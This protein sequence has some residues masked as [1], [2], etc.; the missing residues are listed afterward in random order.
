LYGYT[1]Y[2]VCELAKNYPNHDPVP[3]QNL[4]DAIAAWH[5]DHNAEHIPDDDVLM[6]WADRAMMTLQAVEHAIC[7]RAATA[8]DNGD[9]KTTSGKLTEK[10]RNR[11]V[12]DRIRE[13][14]SADT[15]I[16]KITRDRLVADTGISAGMICKTTAWIGLRDRKRAAKKAEALRSDVVPSNVEEAIEREDWETV[17]RAQEREE[18]NQGQYG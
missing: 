9:S 18:K 17:L 13:L 12:G 3:I 2:I 5:R 1:T 6:T 15:P 10:E 4:H 16:E 14:E 8:V 11:I 7:E